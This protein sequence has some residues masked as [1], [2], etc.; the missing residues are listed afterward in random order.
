MSKLKIGEIEERREG[1]LQRDIKPGDK[2]C[3]APEQGCDHA[4]SD[5]AVEILDAV[6]CD[7]IGTAFLG[8]EMTLAQPEDAQGEEQRKQ[9]RVECHSGSFGAGGDDQCEQGGRCK[10]AADQI[11]CARE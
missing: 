10:N 4:G 9:G 6:A 5:H 11:G 3:D 1:E 8:I 2:T 7:R